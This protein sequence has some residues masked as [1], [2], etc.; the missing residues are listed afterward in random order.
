[1]GELDELAVDDFKAGT[2]KFFRDL[3]VFLEGLQAVGILLVSSVTK[4]P[5]GRGS[6]G[7]P[8]AQGPDLCSTQVDKKDTHIC[9]I[10]AQ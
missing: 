2:I 9:W 10:L 1:M 6:K 4:F 8:S 5:F 3:V 7:T